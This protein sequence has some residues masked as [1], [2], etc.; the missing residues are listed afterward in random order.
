MIRVGDHFPVSDQN[1]LL[2]EN[3]TALGLD[4]H[5]LDWQVSRLSTGERQRLA[6][7]RALQNRPAV[8]LLDEPSSGLDAYHT[9]MMETFIEHYRLLHKTS[10]V[11]VSHDPEQIR[12]VAGRKFAME[13]NGLCEQNMKRTTSLSR[14]GEA[15]NVVSLSSVD[16]AIA[17]SLLVLL[18]LLSMMFSLKLERKILFLGMRMTAQLLLVGLVLR[19]LFASG[20]FLLVMLMS[21]VMLL[22][23]GREVQARQKRKIMGLVRVSDQYMR[24]VRLLI[25]CH[26]FGSA[27]YYSGRTVVHTTI[28]H[29]AAWHAPW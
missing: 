29:S 7:L 3:C 13:Q 6:L 24:H 15:M 17:A 5:I 14:S 19:F 16:L 18:S 28:C 4:P 10:I 12:R 1:S 25:F 23:A 27:G 11:W 9:R 2:A 20:S 26:S 21:T 22:A 8:L